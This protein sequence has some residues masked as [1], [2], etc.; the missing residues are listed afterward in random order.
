[1]V[2]E[3]VAIVRVTRDMMLSVED[4]VVAMTDPAPA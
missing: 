3:R 4:A 2:G 1:M